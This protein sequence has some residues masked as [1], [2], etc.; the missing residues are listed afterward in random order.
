VPPLVPG[1]QYDKLPSY[2]IFAGFVF[3]PLTQPYIDSTLICNCAIKYM[4]E[5]AGEQL[6]II[7]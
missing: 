7:S 3:V 6:V 5:K 2:Y 4:P 1:H